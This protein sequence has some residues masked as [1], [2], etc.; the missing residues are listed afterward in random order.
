MSEW[1]DVVYPYALDSRM[2]ADAF[3]ISSPMEVCDAI[4]SD[5]RK[6]KW[7]IKLLF[8]LSDLIAD[9][10]SFLLGDRE[11]GLLMPWDYFPESFARE[12]KAKE[13][14][15]LERYK[16]KRRNAMDAYNAMRN[17]KEV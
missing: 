15:D 2:T 6:K 5:N 1:I 17:R 16:A 12:K 9:R 14:D 11:E 7:D 8:L 4:E 3:W 10:V 13:K